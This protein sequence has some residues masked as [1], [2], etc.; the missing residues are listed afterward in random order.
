MAVLLLF[1][2]DS[3]QESPVRTVAEIRDA[4][5]LSEKEVQRTVRT[6]SFLPS[7]TNLENYLLSSVKFRFENYTTT[8]EQQTAA[9]LILVLHEDSII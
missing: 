5:S 7:N 6:P 8:N 4:T 3:T 1:N 2:C 9:P